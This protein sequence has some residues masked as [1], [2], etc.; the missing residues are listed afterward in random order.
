MVAGVCSGRSWQQGWRLEDSQ[1]LKISSMRDG[2]GP[3][4][5]C[6]GSGGWQ[7]CLCLWRRRRGEGNKEP[8]LK[9]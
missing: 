2:A 1:M 7:W 8:V 9:W 4:D 3:N 6:G 5:D